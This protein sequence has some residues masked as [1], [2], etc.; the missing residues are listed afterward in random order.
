MT[1]L[2]VAYGLSFVHSVIVIG[3][4]WLTWPPEF[5]ALSQISSELFY[6]TLIYF[7]SR[8]WY[9]A[10]LIYVVLLGVRTVNVI[11]YAHADWQDSHG[12]VLMTALSFTCQY[13]AMYWLFTEPG[14]RW[15][16]RP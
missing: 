2:W 7:V 15:F 9:W 6:V 12:L 13:L 3:E 16:A 10:R 14:R 11:Q 8:G 4:R 5:V 1:A